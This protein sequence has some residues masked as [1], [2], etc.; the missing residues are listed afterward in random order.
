M[1]ISD[2]GTTPSRAVLVHVISMSTIFEH[3][4]QLTKI[5]IEFENQIVVTNNNNLVPLDIQLIV[6]FY[7]ISGR[8]FL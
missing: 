5:E 2:D 8:V 1:W 6:T 3:Y 4:K 7:Q